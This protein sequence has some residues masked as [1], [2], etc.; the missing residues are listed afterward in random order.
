MAT[1]ILTLPRGLEQREPAPEIPGRR[2][3]RPILQSLLESSTAYHAFVGALLAVIAWGVFA[4]INQLVF[5]LQVTALRDYFSWGV[6]VTN[7]V[8][9]IG[10][11][12]AGTLISAILR[13][14]GAQ[15]RRPITR[16]AEA[17]TVFALLVAAPMVLV[18]IGRPE[19][20]WELIAY[21]RIQS[22]ILWDIISVTT[23]LT[24]SLLYLYIPMIPDMAILRDTLGEQAGWRKKW[25][26]LLALNWRGT[27]K[28]AR[29][30]EKAIGAMALIIIPVAIS[31]HTV[32]SWIF[33]MTL[34]PG[35]RSSIFG[36]YFVIG[37]IF[38]GIAAILTAMWVFRRVYHLEHYITEKHFRNLGYL[39]LALNLIYIYFTFAEYLTM[40]Y[41]SSPA[42]QHLL[43]LLLG[44]EHAPTFW[45]MVVF[46]LV[47]PA[48]IV[49]IPRTRT[50]NG[51]FIASIFVNIG[52]WLKR[53]VIVI[54]TLH[55]PFLPIQRVPTEWAQY[56]PTWVE[57]SITAAAFAGFILLYALFS[58]AFPI[59]SLW[60]TREVRQ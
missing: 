5:G 42:E 43:T 23:Y 32:V 46:G 22:P 59:V 53:Y 60:E 52:L 18:D 26:T 4:W 58:K 34:R 14:T 6:Y 48:L 31:V 57:W 41:V 11:S 33:A 49:A 24:G 15:W 16:M 47:I 50:V 35:W 45:F 1:N 21:G 19:R 55:N 3:E 2:E 56:N 13:V 44:T 38:S 8:F 17:I 37:A 7:F 29:R 39:L 40:S 12:H 51:I 30:L 10:I 25:Y 28:Q 27:E 9:F 36:P 54:P 20:I